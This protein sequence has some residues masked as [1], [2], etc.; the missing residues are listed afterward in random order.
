M[1]FKN[2]FQQLIAERKSDSEPVNIST[3]P[4]YNDNANAQNLQRLLRKELTR[5]MANC[6]ECSLLNGGE[7]WA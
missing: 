1:Y 2:V 3:S 7:K 6:D 5:P 4:C